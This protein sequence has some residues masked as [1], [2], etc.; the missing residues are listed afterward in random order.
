MDYNYQGVLRHL[1]CEMCKE[2]VP[3][4]DGW[5]HGCFQNIDFDKI[6]CIG[7]VIVNQSDYDNIEFLDEDEEEVLQA[8][9][10]Q[11]NNPVKIKG[12][13]L[14]IVK[15]VESVDFATYKTSIGSQKMWT[16][17]TAPTQI[18]SHDL[19]TSSVLK[20]PTLIAEESIENNQP[21]SK[22][23]MMNLKTRETISLPPTAPTQINS[24]DLI[25]SS[26]LKK[27]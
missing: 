25:T 27:S 12:K 7:N 2:K 10:N 19:I 5:R 20:N 17:K 1:Y 21:N 15:S 14:P 6:T 26:V 3:Y 23:R 18:N 9:M 11:I 8:D 13:N 22:N 16:V 4:K 24:H